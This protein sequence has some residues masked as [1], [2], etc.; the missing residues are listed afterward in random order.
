MV[1]G[2]EQQQDFHNIDE[3]Y[4][5]VHLFVSWSGLCAAHGEHLGAFL[6]CTVVS[7]PHTAQWAYNAWHN[8]F[9]FEFLMKTRSNSTIL[10]FYFCDGEKIR[11]LCSSRFSC[12]YRYPSMVKP[13]GALN[14]S[15]ADLI[16]FISFSTSARVLSKLLRAY[17][18]T[19]THKK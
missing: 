11:F 19:H 8:S 1:S 7:G 15:S 3:S 17:Q 6:I 10:R 4:L 18:H 13:L 5:S 2:D 16:L 14:S 9:M 12:M